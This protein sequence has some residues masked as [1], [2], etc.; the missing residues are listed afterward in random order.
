MNR[1]QV[2]KNLTCACFGL[3]LVSISALVMIQIFYSQD[4]SSQIQNISVIKE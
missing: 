3:L 1:K 2:Y 4:I